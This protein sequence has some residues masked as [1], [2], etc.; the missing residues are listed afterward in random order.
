MLPC[1]ILAASLAWATQK[2]PSTPVLPSRGLEAATAITTVTGIAI[3]PLLGTAAIGALDYFRTDRTERDQLPWYA[4]PLFWLPALVVVGLVATKDV[5][6]TALPPGLKKPIDVAETIENKVSG[7]VAGGAVVPIVASFF[8]SSSAAV[9]AT[10]VGTTGL[11]MIHMGAIDLTPLLNIL[12]V[13][14]AV[15]AF[16]VVWLMSHV[17]NVLILISPFGAVDAAL[18]AFRTFLLSLL[19]GIHLI[20]PWVGAALSIILILVAYFVAGW[21]FRIMVFGWLYVWDFVTLRRRRF[22]PDLKANWMFT[23]RKIEKTPIRTYGKLRRNEQG[24]LVFEYRPWLVLQKRSLA[25]PQEKLAV[26]RGLFYPEI[27]TVEG[28]K[29]KTLLVLPPRYKK[30][31]EAIGQI[32]GITEM[33]DTGILKGVKAIWRWWTRNLF[34]M[35]PKP[36]NATA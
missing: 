29:E 6:G 3:S 23:G 30:H 25:L 31:E 17:V 9:T 11:A 16:A 22:K 26:G 20:D 36:A 2:E 8:K 12:T 18:K 32:Y 7:F 34:G 27:M 33:R 4:S 28:E 10:D 24:Q 21:S 14:F 35:D 19:A 5:V 13:P 1:L 15:F